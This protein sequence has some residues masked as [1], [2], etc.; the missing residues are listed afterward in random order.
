MFF[1][2]RRWMHQIYYYPNEGKLVLSPENS[3]YAPL[4][5]VGRELDGVKII[6]KAV[7]FQSTII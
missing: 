2:L 5:F 7:A 3:R 1:D 4:V 6:G